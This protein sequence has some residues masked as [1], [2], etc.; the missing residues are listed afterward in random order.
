[1]QVSPGPCS[2]KIPGSVTP[3]CKCEARQPQLG[4]AHGEPLHARFRS[5]PARGHALPWPSTRICGG[6]RQRLGFQRSRASSEPCARDP[7]WRRRGLEDRKRQQILDNPMHARC[8]LAHHAEVVAPDAIELQ[9]RTVSRKPTSTVNGCAA[10]ATHFATKSR[11]WFRR[12]LHGDVPA[13]QQLCASPY[14]TS[15]KSSTK[16]LRDRGGNAGCRPGPARRD[17]DEGRFAQQV[18]I[19]RRVRAC[20]PAPAWQPRCRCTIDAMIGVEDHHAVGSACAHAAIARSASASIFLA[21]AARVRSGAEPQAPRPAAGAFGTLPARMRNQRRNARDAARG[22]R[23]GQA[24]RQRRRSALKPRRRRPG[25]ERDGG[26]ARERDER[27]AV[28]RL[29]RRAGRIPRRAP[30]R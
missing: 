5:S 1:M 30:C 26:Q 19:G 18:A 27:A 17:I 21:L 9:L 28:D 16:A 20:V 23:A 4:D 24:T 29:N 3:H 10:R 13:Q 22:R 7:C 8:L 15:R 14:G 11:A 25:D 6:R 2:R 12:A